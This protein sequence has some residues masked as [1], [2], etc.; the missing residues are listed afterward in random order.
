MARFKDRIDGAKK[1]LPKLAKFA[2]DKDAIVVGLPRGG[3]VTAAEVAKRLHLPLGFMIIKKIGAPRDPELAIGATDP[4]GISYFDQELINSL[5]VAKEYLDGQKYKK[6]GEA[7]VRRALYET[8]FKNPDFSD[9]TIILVD[10]GIAT[11]TSMLAAVKSAKNLGA[12]KII[13]AVPVTAEDSKK[14]F[15]GEADE[16]IAAEVDPSM[17]SVG[18][19]YDF[20]PQV[21]DSEVLEILKN[22]KND[23][24]NK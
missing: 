24:S 13:V 16:F 6:M 12:K 23:F 7:A 5:R 18:E 22:A 1:L 17:S 14:K 19:F 8:S 15:E 4:E 10:D 21:E 3:V 11:G 2:D 20:F 9:R